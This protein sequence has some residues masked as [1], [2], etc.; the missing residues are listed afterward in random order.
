MNF[1]K[2]PCVFLWMIFLDFGSQHP[3]YV[4]WIGM[5]FTFLSHFLKHLTHSLQVQTSYTYPCI[6][7]FLKTDCNSLSSTLSVLLSCHRLLLCLRFVHWRTPKLAQGTVWVIYCHHPDFYY[8]TPGTQASVFLLPTQ[9]PLFEDGEECTLLGWFS[10]SALQAVAGGWVS[11]CGLFWIPEW[12]SGSA[13]SIPPL[14]RGWLR[15][16]IPV[17]EQTPSWNK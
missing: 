3:V 13:G 11:Q 2:G 17:S 10:L 8:H 16:Q 1:L 14:F 12:W 4:Q 15:N 7:F 9:W 5:L 6:L